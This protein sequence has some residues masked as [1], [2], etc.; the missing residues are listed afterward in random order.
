MALNARRE[1]PKLDVPHQVK[2][3]QEH[4]DQY[5]GDLQSQNDYETLELASSHIITH[6]YTVTKKKF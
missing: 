4:M 1:V 5:K 3:A 6:M 2:V